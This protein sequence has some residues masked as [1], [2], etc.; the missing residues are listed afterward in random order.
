MTNKG[1]LFGELL[2]EFRLLSEEALEQSIKDAAQLG[3]PLGRALV[4]SNKL[5]EHEVSLIVAVQS[6]MKIW[7]LPL[8]IARKAVELARK[9]HLA[10]TEALARSG[11]RKVGELPGAVGSLGALLLDSK[12]ISEEQFAEAQRASY[13]SGLPIGRVLIL[14]GVI[15]HSV[16]AKVLELQ[17]M[18]RDG[19]LTF[20]SAAKELQTSQSPKSG[21]STSLAQ[22]AKTMIPIRKGTR[23]GEFLMLAGILTESDLMNALEL[24][25]ERQLTVGAA[26]IELGLLTEQT[27]ESALSLQHRVAD[28]VLDLNEAVKQMRQIAGLHDALTEQNADEQ[29]VSTVVIGELLRRCGLVDDSQIERAIELSTRYPALIGKMLVLAGA[30]DEAT[31]LAALRCQFLIRHKAITVDQGVNALRRASKSEICLDD[32]LDELGYP[33]PYRMRRDV[34]LQ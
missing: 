8:D 34:K 10:I 22:R 11:W 21:L 30:I 23:L 6:M 24:G 16:L 14:K 5:T 25:L 12:L 32:A 2:L 27:L 19:N 15:S 31:L 9:D 1:M 17:R 29:R 3:V 28:G 4:L 7:D 26:M 20:A 13:E 33:V 18:I